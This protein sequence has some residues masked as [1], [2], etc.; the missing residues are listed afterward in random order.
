MFACLR[1]DEDALNTISPTKVGVFLFGGFGGA[2]VS[3]YFNL[4]Y[5][6]FEL[7]RLKLF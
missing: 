6:K 2:A 5:S 1:F 4:K 7:S 3:K